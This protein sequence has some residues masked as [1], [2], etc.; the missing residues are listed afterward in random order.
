MHDTELPLALGQD[1]SETKRTLARAK[2]RFL[3]SISHEIR[4]PMTSILGY[5]ELLASPNL[6]LE[7]QREFLEIIR[8]NGKALMSVLNEAVESAQ[9][10]ASD[11]DFDWA[12][13]AA[14]LSNACE[15]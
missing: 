15:G 14:P 12:K 9:M 2:Q 3:A 10:E 11:V 7:E 8:R 5:A 4:T 1:P 6:S 13:P